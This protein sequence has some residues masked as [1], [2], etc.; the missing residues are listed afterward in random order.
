[1][2]NLDLNTCNAN[3]K[4]LDMWGNSLGIRI[5]QET[6]KSLNL[7]KGMIVAIEKK[8]GEIRIRSTNEGYTLKDFMPFFALNVNTE[9]LKLRGK[10][11]IIIPSAQGTIKGYLSVVFVAEGYFEGL[12]TGSLFSKNNLIVKDSLNDSPYTLVGNNFS[13][14]DKTGNK[15]LNYEVSIEIPQGSEC[16]MYYNENDAI[17]SSSVIIICDYQKTLVNNR[18]LASYVVENKNVNRATEQ[19]KMLICKKAVENLKLQN[20]ELM[21]ENYKGFITG[22]ISEDGLLEIENA[23]GRTYMCSIEH[24]IDLLSIDTPEILIKFNEIVKKC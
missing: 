1:M 6:S 7:K 13:I 4:K 8:F 24:V 23:D 19:R 9:C 18:S 5:P 14:V 2:E 22:K 16:C 12:K 15:S 17:L 3:F 21:V 11:E 20:R 10:R